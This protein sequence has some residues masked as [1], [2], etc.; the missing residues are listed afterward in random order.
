MD[1]N[2]SQAFNKLFERHR[3]VFWYDSEKELRLDFEKL[4]LESIEKIAINNNEFAIK[5]RIL[6]EQPQQKFLL[7]HEGKEPDYLDNWLLDVQLAQGKFSTDQASLLL[8]E[9]E[10]GLEFADIIE[11]HSEFFRS[12][13]RRESLK[14]LLQPQDTKTNICL[15]ML[16]V[17]TTAE[18]R[19]DSI[20]ER[21]LEESAQD[22]NE[23]LKLCDRTQLTE[24]FWQ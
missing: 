7:Y 2:I 6:R 15:K 19:L 21:L 14:K 4:E 10:L 5:Y 20:L 13:Q 11:S 18:P 1:K 22:K 3:I 23:K 9:L 8:T 17:C 12:N 16:A 24:F